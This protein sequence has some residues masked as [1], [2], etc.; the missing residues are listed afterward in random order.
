M[1]DH[2]KTTIFLALAF[3]TFFIAPSL[4]S[5][6]EKAG[7]NIPSSMSYAADDAGT[8]I[9]PIFTSGPMVEKGGK[10]KK[11]KPK[12]VVTPKCD[13]I[14]Q[15]CGTPGDARWCTC[16]QGSSQK[17]VQCGCKG[18]GTTT[19]PQNPPQTQGGAF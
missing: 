13:D 4:G 16:K 1:P 8:G 10:K 7:P 15:T 9:G 17:T 18:G 2:D 12:P 11:K 3:L 19:S 6:A 14:E 5:A